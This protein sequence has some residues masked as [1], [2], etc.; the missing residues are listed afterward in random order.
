V[1]PRDITCVHGSSD[2]GRRRKASDRGAR[3]DT[4]ISGEGRHARIGHRRGTGD[5]ETLRRTQSWRDSGRHSRGG[6]VKKRGD[7]DNGDEVG[8]QSGETERSN[9]WI[10]QFVFLLL[11]IWIPYLATLLD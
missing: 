6:A 11:N 1:A 2:Y 7:R 8:R 5:H 3:A 10:S 4:Q 9:N